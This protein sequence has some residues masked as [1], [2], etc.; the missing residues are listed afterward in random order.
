MRIDPGVWRDGKSQIMFS[1]N[2]VSRSLSVRG[3]RVACQTAS[4][5]D[6]G[7]K[8]ST[9]AALPRDGD[10]TGQSPSLLEMFRWR[11]AGLPIS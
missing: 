11:G 3:S 5:L 7:V 1:S 9:L 8:A 6:M 4:R 10:W 2:R